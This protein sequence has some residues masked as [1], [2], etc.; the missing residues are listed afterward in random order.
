MAEE[1][2]LK[3]SAGEKKDSH[4]VNDSLS[5][6]VVNV[7]SQRSVE[8][9]SKSVNFQDV[10]DTHNDKG[11]KMNDSNYNTVLKDKK[12]DDN[13][14]KDE[15]EKEGDLVSDVTTPYDPSILLEEDVLLAFTRI[16]PS[17]LRYV[18]HSLFL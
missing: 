18:T 5:T 11:V 10:T 1:T 16:S 17:A 4:Q 3:V 6:C 12:K 9:K 8:N 13:E 7:H 14:N 2:K 15:K